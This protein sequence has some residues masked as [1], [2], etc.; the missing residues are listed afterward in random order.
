[1]YSA[2]AD[3][4][5]EGAEKRVAR[6]LQGVPQ[7][8]IR[9]VTVARRATE[10][11]RAERVYA[12]AWVGHGRRDTG[13]QRGEG[14]ARFEDASRRIGTGD[15][16]VEKRTVWVRVELPPKRR[17]NGRRQVVG[18]EG[19]SA[20]ES[21]DVAVPG[22]HRNGGPS[23]V[24]KQAF[25]RLL[26]TYVDR[27]AHVMARNGRTVGLAMPVAGDIDRDKTSTG[28]AG[29]DAV[30]RRLYSSAALHAHDVVVEEV[31]ARRG[32]R[33]VATYIAEDVRG[34]GPMRIYAFRLDVDVK[35]RLVGEALRETRERRIIE[36]APCEKGQRKAAQNM[37][38]D[39]VA[40]Y[41]ACNAKLTGQGIDAG[42]HR[43]DGVRPRPGAAKLLDIYGDAVGRAVVR[44]DDP[45]AIED[46]STGRRE[47]DA[48]KTLADLSRGVRRGLVDLDR[49]QPPG[50]CPKQRHR[51]QGQD[52]KPPAWH[53]LVQDVHF[54]S[55]SFLGLTLPAARSIRER[56]KAMSGV[57]TND[58]GRIVARGRRMRYGGARN[59]VRVLNA[60]Y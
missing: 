18:V 60:Q 39:L 37:A 56:Q 22:V 3:S 25:Q 2:D 47:Q 15:G 5:A 4:N 51:H 46:A 53:G 55:T 20:Y 29:K 31:S 40:G 52:D 58:S 17:R 1:M 54:P 50:K 8:D 19:R 33:T 23:M 45:V 10:A 48:P 57:A 43:V 30:H 6:L 38:R 9:S 26:Q 28:L 14:Y 34:G 41:L 7:P 24:G 59:G 42:I 21:Q 27:K 49:A 36:I 32:L 44:E 12:V 35:T 11:H 16:A 13:L